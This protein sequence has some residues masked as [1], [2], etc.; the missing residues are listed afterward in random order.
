MD[1]K[2]FI[3]EAIKDITGAINEINDELE[4]H[5]TVV[6]PRSVSLAKGSIIDNFYGYMSNEGKSKNGTSRRH[7][8][9]I[10][11]DVAVSSTVKKDGSVGIGVNVAGFK[12][13]ADGDDT[14]ENSKNS[15]LKFSIPVA[16]PTEIDKY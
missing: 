10:S 5:G 9:L 14:A 12:L 16:L 2:D 15:R 7:V 4:L 13:G 1:L 3:K 6:N 8:H 11:F